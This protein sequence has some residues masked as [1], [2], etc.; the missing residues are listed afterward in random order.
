M[1]LFIEQNKEEDMVVTRDLAC[2][3]QKIDLVIE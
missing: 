3:T 2:K 1:E